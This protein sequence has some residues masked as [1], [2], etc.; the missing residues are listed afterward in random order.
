MCPPGIS[1]FWFEYFWSIVL[2]PHVFVIVGC[3]VVWKTRISSDVIFA[4]VGQHALP[5]K[6]APKPRSVQLW[7]H[8]KMLVGV[9]R[10]RAVCRGRLV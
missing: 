4:A 5:T 10:L 6:V 9:S 8:F 3:R 1:V 7:C 2:G